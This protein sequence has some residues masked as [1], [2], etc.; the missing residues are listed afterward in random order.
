MIMTI[1]FINCVV[2]FSTEMVK[3]SRDSIKNQPSVL[4]I[5]FQ[6]TLLKQSLSWAKLFYDYGQNL[7]KVKVD[8]FNFDL[9][10]YWLIKCPTYKYTC[11]LCKIIVFKL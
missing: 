11:I 8:K 7:F 2:W 1:Y 10:C 4:K 6:K 9:Y 5:P 3:S